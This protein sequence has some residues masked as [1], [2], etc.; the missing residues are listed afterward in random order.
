MDPVRPIW[1]YTY[2]LK[3]EKQEHSIL[4]LLI[5]LKID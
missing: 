5:I 1:H 2:V 4:E 3:L